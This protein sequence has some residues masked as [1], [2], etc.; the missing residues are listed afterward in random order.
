MIQEQ[1]D[2]I[3]KKPKAVRTQYAFAAACVVTGVIA[4][5][6]A[7]TLPGR[8]AIKNV[9]PA[10]V[11]QMAAIEAEQASE[12]KPEGGVSTLFET[13]RDGM[14]ALIFNAEKESEV[15]E[16]EDNKTIDIEALLQQASTTNA[17]IEP[18]TTT[19]TTDTGVAS[20][21]AT[22]SEATTTTTT[23]PVAT[24][25]PTTNEPVPGQVI[26]IGTTTKP[27]APTQ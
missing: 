1:L 18:Q 19:T 20:S 22:S 5:F 15:S 3:R 4:I 14:T 25:S 11:N 2:T 7:V 24:S 16:Q 6:W 8:F 27:A 10:V 17:A 12:S 26:L 23:Q 21:T 9:D 13:L